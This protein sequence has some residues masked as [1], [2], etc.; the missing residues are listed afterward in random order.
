MPAG[1]LLE[2]G[3]AR[4]FRRGLPAVIAVVVLLE[5]V[6]V[7]EA[8]VVEFFEVVA[9]EFFKAPVAVLEAVVEFLEA[10]VVEATTVQDVVNKTYHTF[11]HIVVVIESSEYHW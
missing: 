4:R 2:T 7:L 10:V 6:E 5:L 9:A 11:V 1:Y 3:A 8:A